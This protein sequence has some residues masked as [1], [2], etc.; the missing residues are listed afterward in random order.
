VKNITSIIRLAD[1]PRHIPEALLRVFVQKKAVTAEDADGALA[2]AART[3]AD[4]LSAQASALYMTGKL[5][6]RIR[7]QAVYFSA[8][9]CGSDADRQILFRER[10][11]QFEKMTLP[12]NRPV[13]GQ[14]IVSG[15]PLN[16]ADAT[17]Q[18][19]FYDPIEFPPDFV[20]RSMIAV[21]LVA[22]GRPVGCIEI[23][24]RTKSGVVLPFGPEHLELAQEA[25]FFA[26]KVVERALDPNFQLSDRDM[27]LCFAR[28][29]NCNTIQLSSNELDMPLL[30]TVGDKNL[31]RY[32][33]IPLRKLSANGLCAAVSNPLDYQLI[34]DFEIVTGLKIVEKLVAPAGEI[35]AVL[36]RL[37]PETASMTKVAESLAKEYGIE[38]PEAFSEEEDENSAPIISLANKIIADAYSAGAS[39]IHVE[40]QAL[41]LVV[42]YRVDG[43][44]R[45]KLKLP[46]Q[47]HRALVTRLKI[48][49]DL[50]IAERRLP[51]DGRII[52]KKFN[53]ALDVDLRISVA[54]M[55]YGESVVMRI[56]D[57]T[58]SHLPL[59]ALGFSAYNLNIY[60]RIIQI[61]YGMILHTGPTGSGKSMTLFAA[62]NEISTPELKIV[63]AE[64]PIE[65][66]L[67]GIQQLQVHADIGLTFANALRCFLRQDPDVILVGEIRD[68]QTAE[69]AIEAAL[70][71]H[72]VFSTLHTNDAP[73]TVTRLVEM[74]IDPFLVSSTLASVCAQRLVRRLCP[75][76]KVEEEPDKEV[77]GWIECAK[78]GAEIG[79]VYRSAGCEQCDNTG[80]KGR[81]G[82]HELMQIFDP[83]RELIG[84]RKSTE[85]F[86]VEARRSGMRTLFE[87]AMEKVKSGIT[88]PQEAIANAVKN[89]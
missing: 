59:N 56:L 35:Q 54:P 27:A 79:K 67:Q 58:K 15:A 85:A 51:Q 74:D 47:I 53:T 83:L 70:T 6:N 55:N 31:K 29:A 52:F 28:L 49:S 3:I 21:P 46:R 45:T 86:R 13:A 63:T 18:D 37:F 72:V 33:I 84:A 36:Q 38:F 42:R 41:H 69:I 71:G 2:L 89:D 17:V 78:D 7:L 11:E 44:C 9:A 88:S 25:A 5:A 40:P 39:D 73:S 62:L 24:N 75:N 80:Y 60:E 16:I 30:Q 76:C 19:S 4:A 10:A 22:G 61:P 43:V 57:K 66:T 82:I 8:L 12:V 32:Q 77:L 20:I 64:D 50:D 1:V 87:D 81:T 14:V 48:M 65:Y 23:I 68:Q 34:G 26:G